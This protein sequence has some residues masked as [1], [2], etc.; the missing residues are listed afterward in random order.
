MFGFEDSL[1]E[2]KKEIKA[3][4]GDVAFVKNWQKSFDK[5]KKQSLLLQGQYLGGKNDL[6]KVLSILSDMEKQIIS[7]NRSF[8]EAGKELKKYQNS[9]HHEFLISQAHTDF[10]LTYGTLL[11]LCGKPFTEQKDVLIL[12]SE[13]EN[14][15]ALTKEAL[16]KQFPD[17]RALAFFYIDHVDKEIE[18]LPHTDKIRE[19]Q[20]IYTR[21]FLSPISQILASSLGEER[22]KTIME[23][24]LWI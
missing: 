6:E 7:G 14:L 19:V 18:D 1:K 17:F 3:A 23:V 2:L 16:E 5:V 24:E 21:E 8:T 4:G 11:G 22:T 20:N 15:I 10:H 13:V 12:Q 9:F